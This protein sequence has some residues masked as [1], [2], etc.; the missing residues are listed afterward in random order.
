M[1]TPI[2]SETKKEKYIRENTYY[3]FNWSNKKILE[4]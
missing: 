2:R 1:D 4:L 3:D